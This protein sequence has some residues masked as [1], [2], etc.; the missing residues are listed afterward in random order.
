MANNAN[1]NMVLQVETEDLRLNQVIGDGEEQ[2]VVDVEL[3]VPREKPDIE[4]ILKVDVR[5]KPHAKI[6]VIE[7]KVIIDGI[8]C[9]NVLYV[10][11]TKE[12]DQPVHHME[13]TLNFT[14]FVEVEGA[15][16]DMEAN[17]KVQVENVEWDI[18]NPCRI[19]VSIVLAVTARVIEP[20]EI[21]VVT[22]MRLMP[23]GAA[24]TPTPTPTVTPATP[25]TV[26][27]PGTGV[28][29]P[30]EGGPI[31][32]GNMVGNNNAAEVV[33]AGIAQTEYTVAPGDTLGH[34]AQRF[35]VTVNAIARANNIQNVN[36]IRVGQVLIIP[37]NNNNNM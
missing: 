12:G 15:T 22:D 24:P 28:T 18:I 23:P 13:H 10:G 35:G 8:L 21:E 11:D 25:G 37:G 34:I 19:R 27:I 16:R 32:T 17:V 29:I 26:T 4:K 5:V 30:I 31:P 7:D 3:D 2:I 20:R 14:A 36:R 1:N 6:R 9:V 33:V